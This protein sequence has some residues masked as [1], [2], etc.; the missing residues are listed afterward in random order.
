MRRLPLL[1]LLLAIGCAQ[2]SRWPTVPPRLEWV[3]Q[4][5]IIRGTQQ[6]IATNITSIHFSHAEAL[7]HRRLAALD[8]AIM[9]SKAT[10]I[11]LSHATNECGI[12][13]PNAIDY[14]A[15]KD[16]IGEDRTVQGRVVKVGRSKQAVFLNFHDPYQGHFSGVIFISAWKHFPGRF[17]DLYQ[18]QCVRIRGTIKLY[19]NAP[20]IIIAAPEQIMVINIVN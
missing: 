12:L 18:G 13:P 1:L 8:H 5:P 9:V 14:A 2:T 10:Q 17:E 20:E 16:H 4:I 11:R 19:N 7:E 3:T 6:T 15:S